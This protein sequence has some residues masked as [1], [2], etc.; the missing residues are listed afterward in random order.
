M[1]QSAIATQ[2]IILM[3][4]FCLPVLQ[5]A[6]GILWTNPELNS[7]FVQNNLGIIISKK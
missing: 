2:F 7:R 4:G 6:W 1:L 5:S 3:Y